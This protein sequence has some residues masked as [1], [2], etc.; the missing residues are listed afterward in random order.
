D[1]HAPDLLGSLGGITAVRPK[2][3]TWPPIET[4]TGSQK[5]SGAMHLEP[6]Q[7]GFRRLCEMT[8]VSAGSCSVWAP[9]AVPG[10]EGLPGARKALD[11]ETPFRRICAGFAAGLSGRRAEAKGKSVRALAE[12][13]G[14]EPTCRNYPTIRFRVGAVMTTSVPLQWPP[15]GGRYTTRTG[16]DE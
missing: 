15:C 10:P 4:G 1:T 9:A 3:T 7:R 16:L 13:V 6:L 2:F 14:F 12:R 5:S 11:G 8:G